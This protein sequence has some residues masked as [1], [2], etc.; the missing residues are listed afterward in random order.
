M[1]RPWKHFFAQRFVAK[2]DFPVV[3]LS[4]WFNAIEVGRSSQNAKGASMESALIPFAMAETLTRDH[5]GFHAMSMSRDVVYGEQIFR[6]DQA[7]WVIDEEGRVDGCR[8]YKL[9]R[10]LLGYTPN[11]VLALPG[12]MLDDKQW[13]L[14]IKYILTRYVQIYTHK[15]HIQNDIHVP[16]TGTL[17]NHNA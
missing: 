14:Y 9:L 10:A 4:L 11:A 15:V 8:L 17:Q 12:S 1:D 16:G 2:K 7:R 6:M 13:M 3:A 5:H